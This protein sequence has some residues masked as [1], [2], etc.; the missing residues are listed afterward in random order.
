MIPWLLEHDGPAVV[1]SV[2]RDVFDAT[3]TWRRT[4][5]DVSAWDPGAPDS[6]SWSPVQGCRSWAFALRQGLWLAHAVE[7]GDHH[8]ARY[9]NAEAAKLL[10]PLLHAA[11]LCG[12]SI[13][14]VIAWLDGQAE[15][16]PTEILAA[17]DAWQSLAQARE[18]YDEAADSI[19]AN[20]TAKVFMGPIT[21]NTNRSYVDQLLGQE[22]QEHD[23]HN[24]FRSKASAQALQQLG[25]DRALMV[26]GSLPPGVVKLE[27]FWKA[28]Q[29]AKR[30]G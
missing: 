9:W 24:S 23:D 29:L 28:R 12:G 11:A 3:A 7:T 21:D 5:G 10:A 2:K 27:A 25:D 22:L 14:T 30:A 6:A 4:K 19:L 20:S 17:N 18:R 16:E 8:A 1:T 26:P 13:E 15:D